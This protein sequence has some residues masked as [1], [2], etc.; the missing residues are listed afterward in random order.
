MFLAIQD[1]RAGLIK[2]LFQD[3]LPKFPGWKDFTSRTVIHMDA[4]LYTSTL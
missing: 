1:R 3:T 2:G 4:D